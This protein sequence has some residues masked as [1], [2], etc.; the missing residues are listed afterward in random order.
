M[1]LPA[2]TTTAQ[3]ALQGTGAIGAD[4]DLTLIDSRAASAHAL[5]AVNDRCGEA[6]D[7]AAFVARLGPPI[8]QE[9]ARWAYELRLRQG[10][11]G[12]L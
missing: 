4:L 11:P 8:S 6:I 7:V 9:L 3:A 2:H 10:L 5:H 12:K 1:A